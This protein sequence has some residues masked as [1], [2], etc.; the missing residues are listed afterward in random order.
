MEER[1]KALQIVQ[2]LQENGFTAYFA[3]GWVRDHL[4]GVD[5]YDID[6]ATDA[7]VKTIQT[8][9]EKTIPIG[10]QFG[11][12]VV[13]IGEKPFEVAT[14]RSDVSYEDGRRP[15]SVIFTS[16]KEDA[17]RRDFTINGMFFDPVQETIIDYVGGKND[18]E[19]QVIRAIGNPYERIREDRLRMLRAVRFACKLGFTL[20]PETRKAIYFFRK[21]L[22]PFVAIERIAQELEK[23]LQHQTR[24]KALQL[25]FSLELL[26]E[27][28]PDL[29]LA[30][31]KAL[32]KA[33]IKIEQFPQDVPLLIYLCIL[34]KNLDVEAYATYLKRS[35]KEKLSALFWQ[36]SAALNEKDDLYTWA[37]FYA[38]P[39]ADRCI[40]LTSLQKSS[41][42]KTA[43]LRTHQARKKELFPFIKR[44]QNKTPVLNAS[45]LMNKGITAGKTLGDLLK[46]AE[47]LSV[48]QGITDP[49]TLWNHLNESAKL[50]E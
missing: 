40:H 47:I 44:L 46:K 45:Y 22:F 14:F 28:F 25:L 20:D 32:E 7:P 18:I 23:M 36:K 39:D 9:F 11:I 43:F 37:S 13:V 16:A 3:G 48:N 4:L 2:R 24:K 21:G 8:L 17:S 12:L 49:D 6:I 42:K 34:Q 38:H 31:A 26:Q 19:K 15:T 27:I 5:S 10:L 41:E 30:D 50:E 35:K 29:Q 1:L 33:T